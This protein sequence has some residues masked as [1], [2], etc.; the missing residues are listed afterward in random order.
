MPFIL[1]C[2]RASLA[3]SEMNFW[4]AREMS[5]I[6][7]REKNGCEKAKENKRHTQAAKALACPEAGYSHAWVRGLK[8]SAVQVVTS[9][10]IRDL[11]NQLDD[12]QL[13]LCIPGLGGRVREWKP[14]PV[15]RKLPVC[16]DRRDQSRE[17]AGQ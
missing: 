7:E 1:Q 5:R 6:L 2:C 9:H 10:C 11:R 8:T 13:I 16:V 4:A 12:R 3:I 17:L 15:I 14:A